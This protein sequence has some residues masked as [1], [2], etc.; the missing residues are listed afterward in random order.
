MMKPKLAMNNILSDPRSL[1]EFAVENAFSGIEWS[2]YLETIPRTP[3]EVTRWVEDISL[4]APL[5]VRFHCPFHQVDLGHDDPAERDAAE[6]L[7]RHIVYLVSKAGGRYLTIH[8]GLGRDSTAPLSWETSIEN[9]RRLVQY[10]FE[11]R[12]KVCL[13]NL[14]W[15]WTSRPQ[16]FEKLIRK[17][18]AGVTFD[19]GHAHACASV[20]SQEYAL[21]DFVT[22]HA[23]R[24][25]NAHVYHTELS[26]SGHTPPKTLAEI[27]ERLTILRGTACDWW[28]IE[29]PA[30]DE[31]LRT[32]EILDG[33]LARLDEPGD[34]GP[35]TGS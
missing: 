32:K 11:R 34:A 14:A 15:G 31:L 28:V 21:E 22:P 12:V 6:A 20:A 5:E 26:G 29:I 30:R 8:I 27:E 7:F 1:K 25:Y 2:F 3:T 16:L 24:V 13:E 9:L 4:L 33:Y 35:L 17:S 18:G 10:G 19:I 23:D